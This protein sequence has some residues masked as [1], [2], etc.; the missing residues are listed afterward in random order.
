M[1]D[2]R[3]W[4]NVCKNVR[5]DAAEVVR[6]DIGKLER[7]TMNV[8]NDEEGIETIAAEVIHDLHLVLRSLEK[9]NA[10]TDPIG[11]L[12]IKVHQMKHTFQGA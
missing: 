7:I 2:P 11:E 4:P 1:T 5:D 8:V 10:A 3:L 9:V 12:G 6:V